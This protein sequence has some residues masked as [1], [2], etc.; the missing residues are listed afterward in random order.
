[1]LCSQDHDKVQ[2][3]DNRKLKIIVYVKQL[4]ECLT[5]AKNTNCI[6]V[7]FFIEYSRVALYAILLMDKNNNG[8]PDGSSRKNVLIES[9]DA[10]FFASSD[11]VVMLACLQCGK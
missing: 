4:H 1:M 8:Y 11:G 6:D 5:A 2:A 3:K 7:K 10:I 9:K